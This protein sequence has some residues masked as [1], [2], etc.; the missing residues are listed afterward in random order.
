MFSDIP[1]KVSRARS[2]CGAFLLVMLSVGL[3]SCQNSQDESQND[4]SPPVVEVT[5]VDYAFSSP[6][7][8]KSGWNTFRMTNK[9]KEHH[10]FVITE[11]PEGVS[12]ADFHDKVAAPLD[13]MR[14]LV[15]KGAI[16]T[17]AAQKKL[18]R[19][20]PDWFPQETKPMG[21]VSLTAPGRTAKTT[22]KL[23]PGNYVM[24]CYVRTEERRFHFLRG[25]EKPLVVTKDS[26][27]AMPPQADMS[28]SLSKGQMQADSVV[29]S[30]FRT[31]A[32]HYGKKAKTDPLYLFN[33]HLH[34][35][36]LDEDTSPEGLAG[37]MK[38]DPV[39]PSPVEFLGGP[40]SMLDGNTAYMH[41]DL[42]PGRY[43]WVLGN[44]PKEGDLQSFTVK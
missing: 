42:S 10:L 24:E 7:T 29:S 5:A 25:M 22:L 38:W 41:V 31:V 36:R 19:M 30:G 35:A 44:P 16:D 17:T 39:M 33:Q 26:T 13:S 6:D 43:A 15:R 8:V 23:K 11:L 12:Y 34:L 21:G 1:A 3:V 37:W 4:K 20:I 32:V 18:A 14:T 28:I 40:Q 2:Y 9:G 27:D